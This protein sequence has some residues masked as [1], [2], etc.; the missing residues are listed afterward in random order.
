MF[1]KPSEFENIL[2]PI[3]ESVIAPSQR[4]AVSFDAFFTHTLCHECCHGIG[5]HS[6]TL[7]DGRAS[8]VRQELQEL[9]GTLE[10]AKADIVGLWALKYLVDKGILPSSL[11]SSM[12]VAFVAGCFRSVRF[13]L[14]EAHGKGQALQFNWILE[15]G[16]LMRRPDGMFEVDFAKMPIA[17][18]SLSH[19]ILTIQAEGD[20]A[21]A[22]ALLDKYA[23]MSAPL[24]EALRLLENA[25]IKVD[26]APIFTVERGL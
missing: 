4:G 19:A 20:K 6:I 1:Q 22:A 15:K 23:V 24:G 12:Y 18:A 13:G 21:G 5:P 2:L 3:A 8:T 25:E 16:G 14:A 7:P 17:V 10:E 26:V 9:Y 11:S